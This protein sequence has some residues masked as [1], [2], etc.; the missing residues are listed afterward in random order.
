MIMHLICTVYM[1]VARATIFSARL[2]QI[3]DPKTYNII[4]A[5]S[6]QL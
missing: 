1:H 6:Y 4:C 2:K 3:Y 5:V